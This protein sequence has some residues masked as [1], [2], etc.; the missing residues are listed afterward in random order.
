M[1]SAH[2]FYNIVCRV[3]GWGWGGTGATERPSA[4]FSMRI[5]AESLSAIRPP[6]P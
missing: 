1:K 5:K 3:K 4:I 2:S 6:H